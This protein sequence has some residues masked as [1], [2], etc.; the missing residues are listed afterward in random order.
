[1]C[2]RQRL[3]LLQR[4]NSPSKSSHFFLLLS[5]KVA[6]RHS[7][8]NEASPSASQ[9][10]YSLFLI[11]TTFFSP[12]SYILKSL[13]RGKGRILFWS[14]SQASLL[15]GVLFLLSTRAGKSLSQGRTQTRDKFPCTLYVCLHMQA[16]SFGPWQ[17]GVLA[18]TPPPPC[19]TNSF[20]VYVYGTY[21]C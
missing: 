5:A 9:W 14:L 4:S 12:F 21:Q 16:Q 6:F 2:Y 19:Q 18:L 1:M 3:L 20:F 7:S 17:E 8:S 10:L 11:L 13:S 15:P